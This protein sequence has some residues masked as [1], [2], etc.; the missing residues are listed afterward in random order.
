MTRKH[1]YFTGRVQGVGFRYRATYLAQSL[2]LTGW[3]SNLWDGRVEM[4]LQGTREAVDQMVAR[5]Y[6]QRFIE[7]EDIEIKEIPA[8]GEE[9]RFRVR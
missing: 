8:I 3:V 2:G 7:I 1:F 6:E 4:E 5:L 9:R